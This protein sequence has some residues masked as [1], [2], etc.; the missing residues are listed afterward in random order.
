[1]SSL[2]SMPVA[3]VAKGFF[4][5]SFAEDFV[6]EKAFTTLAIVVLTG[7]PLTQ[8]LLNQTRL[9]STI[10]SIQ[11]VQRYL[12]LQEQNSTGTLTNRAVV[13]FGNLEKG[14][15]PEANGRIFDFN[16]AYLAPSQRADPVLRNVTCSVNRSQITAI[17]G[18]VA[19]GK[20][21]LLRA[22]LG[23][24]T[25]HEGQVFRKDCKIAYCGQKPWLRNSSI[26]SNIIGPASF[27]AVRYE[28]AINGAALGH[29]LQQLPNRDLTLVG[30]SGGNL[31]GGQRHRV[32]SRPI[33][34]VA[35]SAD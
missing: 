23:E 33:L 30:S 10:A 29:D 24:A 27:D 32:V 9:R 14:P 12:L 25:I 5:V 11:G 17:M 28:V 31:S 35:L 13:P 1:M 15:E 26:R 22:M 4:G 7:F 16:G 34:Y 8:V 19:S 6:P 18:P 21:T 2:A 20:T 3:A